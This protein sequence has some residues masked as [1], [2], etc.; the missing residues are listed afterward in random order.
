M[1]IHGCKFY[2]PVAF[3]LCMAQ[4]FLHISFIYFIDILLQLSTRTPVPLQKNMAH[5]N[6]SQRAMPLARSEEVNVRNIA[7]GA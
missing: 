7:K 5:E 3:P 1:E 6:T 2:L 4:V